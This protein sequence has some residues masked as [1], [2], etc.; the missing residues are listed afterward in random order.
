[1]KEREDELWE[2]LVSLQA[3]ID[4][5]TDADEGRLRRIRR[6]EKDRE[7]LRHQLAGARRKW[8]QTRKP[9][10][11]RADGPAPDPRPALEVPGVGL[12]T[13][14]EPP[15]T[16]PRRDLRVATVL[17]PISAT[18]FG[19]EFHS[20]P[21]SAT[22]W[23]PDIESAGADLLFVESAYQGH[24]G[25][26]ATRVARFGSPSD[27]LAG[28]VNWCRDHGVP[29]VFWN[30]E[31]PINFDWFVESARLFDHVFTVD[32]DQIPRYQSILGHDRV[33]LLQF[34][35]QPTIHYPGAEEG[36]T[37]TV[38][39]AGS[40]F[41]DKH[42]KRREQMEMLLDPAREFGLQIFDRHGDT[43][44]PRFRWPDK[45]RPHIVG[46][47]TY[48]Q[49]VEAYRRYK[50]FLNVNTVTDSP[51]MCARRVFELAACRTPIVSGPALALDGLSEQIAVV[52]SAREASD[53]I[54]ATLSERG[55]P[56]SGEW[57]RNGHTAETRLGSV[58]ESIGLS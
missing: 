25:S 26:W 28:L 16:G 7:A 41:A 1:M 27:R 22:S 17:D 58:L 4:R 2:H 36:R 23:E 30:K 11:V 49:T 34:F 43:D 8:W 10:P 3:Q 38:A 45:Y 21:I 13:E 15:T 35:A 12:I 50:V 47:L 5:L 54:A 51:T 52:R 20:R 57:I 18:V 24:D 46:S 40:Y 44:D 32:G 48:L 33:H 31:D 42:P 56:V 6:L 29:T 39:F 9:R 14:P 19:P 53:A 55:S 37:G